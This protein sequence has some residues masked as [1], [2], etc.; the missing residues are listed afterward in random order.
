MDSL[1]LVLA[2]VAALAVLVAV[3]ALMRGR[4]GDDR[5]AMVLE[6]SARR[7]AEQAE[8]AAAA[9]AEL[10]GRVTQLSENHAAAQAKI[11]E[12]MQLQEREVAK[13]LDERLADVTRK[14]G[15]SLEKSSTKAQT[16]LSEL[17]QRLAIIDTA[18]KNITELSTQVVGLQDILSNKQARGAFGEIQLND[19]VSSILPP[20]AYRFQAQIG[21][22]RRVDCL[23]DLPNPPGSIAIDA[24]FPLESYHALMNASSDAERAAARKQMAT[25]IL[26]H[27]KDISARYIVPGETAESALMFLPSEAIYAELHAN[28]PQVVEQSWKERVWIVSPTTLMATLNTVR[29]VLKDARMREQAHVIQKEVRTMLTDVGRLDE[30]VGKLETHFNQAE[31][32]IRDIR[33]STNKITR[34]G[35]LIEEIE[36]GTA[37]GSGD[38]AADLL[39]TTEHLPLE[40]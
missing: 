39:G 35:E 16:S 21:E 2:A 23:I 29:A 15:E 36:V 24:K 40:S 22:N 12:L 1:T 37:E 20:N 7:Q 28:L 33:T 4:G 34:R 5:I 30:R 3:V 17:Q 13:R 18:Q 32:D 31:K 25:A 14:V 19:L 6:E 27:V 38:A 11:A 26:K 9:Q 8:R 10:A